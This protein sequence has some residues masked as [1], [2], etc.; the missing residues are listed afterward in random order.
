MDEYYIE[1]CIDDNLC[2]VIDPVYVNQERSKLVLT[3]FFSLIFLTFFSCHESIYY[4][5]HSFL[6]STNNDDD[7]KFFL[8]VE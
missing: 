6:F 3:D 1:E 4:C 5:V 7:M 8:A 2:I